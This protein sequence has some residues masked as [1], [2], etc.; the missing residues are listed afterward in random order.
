MKKLTLYGLLTALSILT[1]AQVIDFPD[2]HLKSKLLD[3][4]NVDTNNDG[5]IDQQEAAAVISLNLRKS[6]ISDLTGIE[7]FTNLTEIDLSWNKLTSADFSSNTALTRLMLGSNE[8]LVNLNISN[9]LQLTNLLF[10]DSSLPQLDLTNHTKLS[11]LIMPRSNFTAIDLS[12]NIHL[13]HLVLTGSNQL[14]G[15]DLSNNAQLRH[16][17]LGDCNMSNWSQP[18][19]LTANTEIWALYISGNGLND[20]DLTQNSELSIMEA[21]NN[22]FEYLDFTGN[23]NLGAVYLANNRLKGFDL[24]KPRKL[25]MLELAGNKLET[26]DLRDSPFIHTLGFSNNPELTHAFLTGLTFNPGRLTFANCPN[27][28]FICVDE[29]EVPQVQ[30]LFN[31]PAYTPCTVSTSCDLD[32]YLVSGTIRYDSGDDGCDESDIGFPDAQFIFANQS[33]GEVTR[34]F[35][36]NS[37]AYNAALKDGV[38]FMFSNLQNAAYF[39][40]DP[41]PFPPTVISF[42]QD[43]PNVNKDFC[44]SANGNFNDLEIMILPIVQARPGFQADYLIIYKNKGTTTQSGTVAFNFSDEL[45][46]YVS[47][48]VS[49][50]GVAADQL[51]WGLSDLKPLESRSLRVTLRVNTPTDTAPVNDGDLLAFETEVIGA[52]DLTPGDNV[53]VLNQTVVNSYDPNDKTC[54]EGEILEPQNVGEYLHYMIRFENEGTADA[55]NVRITDDIDTTKLDITSFIPLHASHTYRA[56]VHNEKEVEF[57]FDDIHLP[58]DDANNDGYVLFKIKSKPSLVLG[59]E[60]DNGAAIYFDFNPPVITEVETVT[61]MEDD[62]EPVLPTFSDLFILSP[63]PT[64]GILNLQLK[65]PLIAEEIQFISIHDL[66]GNVVGYFPG[67]TRTFNVSYLFPSNYVMQIQTIHHVYSTQFV[68]TF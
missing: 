18:L 21:R 11:Q 38:Y 37:G 13:D 60:I 48:S 45:L 58:F 46:T 47:A 40:I 54:L 61:V 26:L 36:L 30:D 39:N 59:D 49:P 5:Q 16:L 6:N 8:N 19:D 56:I 20:L 34:V 24:A 67:S 7:Y 4:G 33:T 66:S 12:N 15:L 57:L 28:E 29:G 22:N 43:G 50:S 52:S 32:F 3:L 63:N 42:P 17:Y 44:V 27:L 53:A 23:P 14:T 31:H 10:Y 51:L 68:K 35:P 9:N 64:S 2:T 55:V 1:Y 25:Q 65:N 41:S 62:E